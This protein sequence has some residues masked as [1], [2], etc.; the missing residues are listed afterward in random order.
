V[1]AI[2]LHDY[3]TY[4]D[5]TYGFAR[6][7]DDKVEPELCWVDFETTG[8]DNRDSIPL[9]IGVMITDKFC[10]VRAVFQSLIMERNWQFKLNHAGEVVRKM[11][12]KNGL[13]AHLQRTEII[14][15]ANGPSPW[16][17]VLSASEVNKQLFDFLHEY[18]PGENKMPMAGSTVNFDRY[19]MSRWLMHCNDYLHYRN[20]DVTTLKNLCRMHNPRVYAA[21]PQTPAEDKWHRPL[22]DLGGSMEEYQ[23]YLDNFLHVA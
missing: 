17:D 23:F 13:E 11:H 16:F 19:F 5:T 14:L 20:V 12:E 2:K 1:T 3:T 15:P 10:N 21:L 4:T 9:E 6:S 18:G 22:L 8:L 7:V